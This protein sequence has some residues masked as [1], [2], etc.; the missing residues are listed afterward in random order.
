METQDE[1]GQ[2][3]V[4]LRTRHYFSRME[5][6]DAERIKRSDISVFDPTLRAAR[7]L[8]FNLFETTCAK[9]HGKGVRLD[10]ALGLELFEICQDMAFK[11]SGLSDV[12]SPVHRNPELLS[13]VQEVLK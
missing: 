5:A 6:L 7:E 11:A 3:P 1:F 13:L 10:E 8:R 2:D 12:A 4:I 9:A